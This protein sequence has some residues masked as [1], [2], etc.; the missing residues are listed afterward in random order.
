MSVNGELARSKVR[1]QPAFVAGGLVRHRNR[2]GVWRVLAV[3]HLLAAI[4]PWDELAAASLE[5]S[6][7]G[8]IFPR[9]EMLERL[10]PGG[11]THG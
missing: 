2:P 8:V 10:L 5:K 9:L 4:E 7:A 3:S 11:R 1:R 6:E